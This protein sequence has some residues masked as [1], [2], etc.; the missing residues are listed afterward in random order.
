MIV[1]NPKNDEIKEI[2]NHYEVV[3]PTRCKEAT[4]RSLAQ[5]LQRKGLG[6]QWGCRKCETALE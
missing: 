3:S 4:D 1:G 5:K 6:G 2:E